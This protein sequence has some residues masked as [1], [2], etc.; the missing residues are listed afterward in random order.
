MSENES[1]NRLNPIV[2]WGTYLFV[3]LLFFFPT[4]FSQERLAGEGVD[5]FGT[6]WFY[7]WVK[8]CLINGVDPSFTD[9]F[10]HP[11]GKDIFAHTGNNLLDAYI[12]IPFQMLFGFPQYYNVFL[13]SLLAANC[14]AFRSMA[15]VIINCPLGVWT[16]TILWMVNPFVIGELTMGRPTQCIFFFALLSIRSFWLLHKE[17][18]FVHAFFLGFW[19]ALQGW[20]YWYSGYFLAFLLLWL[21]FFKFRKG[22][23][24]SSTRTMIALYGMSVLVCLLLIM[25]AVFGM[26]QKIDLGLVP[27][28]GTET[29][30]WMELPKL[31]NNVDSWLR[32]YHLNEPFGHPMLQSWLWGP[33]AVLCITIGVQRKLWIGGLLCVLLIGTGA[34]WPIGEAKIPMYHYLFLYHYLPFFDRLW[35]PYRII[36]FGFICLAIS[37]GLLVHKFRTTKWIRWAVLLS[38]VVGLMEHRTLYTMPIQYSEAKPPAVLDVMKS[39]KG[40][41]IELPIGYVRPTIMWQAV[42]EQPTFGGMGENARIFLPTEHKQRLRNPFIRYLYKV[43]F[44]PDTSASFS[45]KDQERIEEQGF[46]FILLDRKILEMELLLKQKETG[47]R[48]V[49]VFDVQRRLTIKFGSPISISGSY[50]LWD[51]QNS[52]DSLNN[53]LEGEYEYLWEKSGISKYELELQNRN[54]IPK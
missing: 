3:L 26:I 12:S 28:L 49:L 38:I 48:S 46:R 31:N 11:Y 32:G 22:S 50:V 53:G 54:R 23:S 8:Y 45:Y 47:D 33:L 18:R 29:N 13:F 17:P 39:K 9:I 44:D 27:G 21:S 41:V 6:V 43:S 5:L 19:T 36:G 10:F 34:V 25:P 2:E 16:A 40:G 14:L 20:I 42:H 30:S 15:K 51:L 1:T 7:W 37:G 35:F 24:L 4:L 52:N